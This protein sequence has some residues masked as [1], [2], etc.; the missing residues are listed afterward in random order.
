MPTKTFQH[1]ARLVTISCDG[2][3][4]TASKPSV[5][6]LS[7]FFPAFRQLRRK[8]QVYMEKGGVMWQLS[9]LGMQRGTHS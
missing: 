1:R 6:L 3:V 9:M 4:F 5:G 8:L 7:D 2:A